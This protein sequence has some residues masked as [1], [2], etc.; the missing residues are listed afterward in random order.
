[1]CYVLLSL[2]LIPAVLWIAYNFVIGF[3]R[4]F[5]KGMERPRWRKLK[6]VWRLCQIANRRQNL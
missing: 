5:R 2:L 1:M 3:I 4:G 6:H